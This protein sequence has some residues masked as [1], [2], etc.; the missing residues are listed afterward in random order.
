MIQVLGFDPAAHDNLDRTVI[1]Y[2]ALLAKAGLVRWL[3]ATFPHLCT[4]HPSGPDVADA[5]SRTVLHWAVLGG[6][7]SIVQNLCGEHDASPSQQDSNGWTALHFA[8][9][10]G[11]LPVLEYLVEMGGSLEAQD[12]LG[13]T[14]R[15][16]LIETREREGAVS[17]THLRAHETPEHL[18]C[19]LLLEKK[20]IHHSKQ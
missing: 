15:D 4:L 3:A 5:D 6:D 16:L 13:V 19:R 7:L 2:A 20:K 12:S 17:Y 18:V 14:P 9:H 11:V 8:A 1:M 10:A